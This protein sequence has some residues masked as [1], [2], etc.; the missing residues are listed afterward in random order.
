MLTTIPVLDATV[1]T[2][3]VHRYTFLRLGRLADTLDSFDPD[4]VS[5]FKFRACLPLIAKS[6]DRMTPDV[7]EDAGPGACAVLRF[8]V[9]LIHQHPDRAKAMTEKHL[10]A[11][12]NLV[13]RLGCPPALLETPLEPVKLKRRQKPT[14]AQK[15][16]EEK[17]REEDAA[18]K[19]Q[20]QARRRKAAARVAEL[21]Q[22]R[23]VRCCTDCACGWRT[24]RVPIPAPSRG[25]LPA[26]LLARYAEQLEREAQ[27]AAV[28]IQAKAVRHRAAWC[29]TSTRARLSHAHSHSPPP[30]P[31][32]TATEATR[33][34]GTCGKEA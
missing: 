10:E 27:E 30:L 33:S 31:P 3:R 14:R 15:E 7:F 34:Q 4:N 26:Y 5:A 16:A 6:M 23:C 1:D 12:D 25:H 32:W 21:K 19:L 28:R 8:L 9:R 17:A 20:A 2:P 29:R 24:S 11:L 18:T 13:A 22:K